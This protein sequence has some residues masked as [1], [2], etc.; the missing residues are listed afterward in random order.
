MVLSSGHLGGAALPQV[1][2]TQP[3]QHLPR[4]SQCLRFSLPSQAERQ[5]SVLFNGQLRKQLAV[6]E[7]KPKAFTTQR[8]E[9]V[10]VKDTEGAPLEADFT[11]RHRKDTCK[12]VEQGGL[13]RSALPGDRRNFATTQRDLGVPDGRRLTVEKINALGGQDF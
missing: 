5:G 11:A 1:G 4:G 7:D 9:L 3:T 13:S 2:E 8:A 6:L 12:A 10:I